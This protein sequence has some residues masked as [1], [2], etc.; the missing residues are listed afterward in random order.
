MVNKQNII[1]W[2]NKESN[3]AILALIVF[4]MRQ[5]GIT[6]TEI[7]IADSILKAKSA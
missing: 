1:K 2:A 5:R 7:G 3:E 4:L 6:L